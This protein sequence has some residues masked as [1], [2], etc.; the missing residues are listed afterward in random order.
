MQTEPPAAPMMRR[1][2]RPRLSMR[3][4]IQTTV[5]TVL[6]TPKIPVVK[7][8]I[9]GGKKRISHFSLF[10]DREGGWYTHLHWYQR[11]RST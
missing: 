4:N 8:P 3:K 1:L 6:T 7:K 9:D 10:R 2:R 11:H 5:R